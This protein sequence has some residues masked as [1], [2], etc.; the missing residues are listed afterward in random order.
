MKRRIQLLRPQK[1][2]LN[3]L[4][5]ISPSQR[6]VITY[7]SYNHRLVTSF[8]LICVLTVPKLGIADHHDWNAS[9]SFSTE[10]DGTRS[11]ILARLTWNP[12]PLPP[13]ATGGTYEISHEGGGR[14]SIGWGN[15]GGTLRVLQCF[16]GAAEF[17]RIYEEIKSESQRFTIEMN[18]YEGGWHSLSHKFTWKP[19]LVA[20]NP[21]PADGTVVILSHGQPLELRWSLN[22]P[23]SGHHVYFSDDFEDV[24]ERTEDAF[25]GNLLRHPVVGSSESDYPND[26]IPGKTYYWRVDEIDED[27]TKFDGDIWSFWTKPP[28]PITDPNLVCWW[29]FDLSEGIRVID[30]SGHGCEGT[31]GGE[32]QWVDGY[33]GRAV[34]FKAEGDFV[35]RSLDKASDWP[36]G[37]VAFWVKADTVGQDSGG[38]V[39]SS[40][41][42]NFSGF[43]I[44]VDGGNPGNYQVAPGGLTYGA[45]ATDWVHLALTFEN[46]VAKLYYNGSS[47][48]SGPLID[49]MFNQF[50]LGVSRNMANSLLGA[51]DDFFIYDYAL[52]QNE[53]KHVMRANTLV[54]W[55]PSPANGS[56]ADIKE[57]T[58]LRWSPGDGAFQHDVYFG[59]NRSDVVEADATNIS[60]VY[61]GRQKLS[62]YTPT[63]SLGSGQ[64]YFWRIDEVNEL[65]DKTP[66]KGNIWSFTTQPEIAY[67]PYPSD[68]SKLPQQNVILTWMPGSAGLLHDVYFGTDFDHVQNADKFD[69]TGVYQGRWPDMSF[70]IE[71]LDF[72]QTYYW[73]IDEVEADGVTLHKGNIWNFTVVHPEETHYYSDGFETGR[74]AQP[75]WQ[76]SGDAD[77]L[78]SVSEVHASGY[79]AQA[80]NIGDSQSTSLI[81]EGSFAAGHISFWRRVSCEDRFDFLRFYI[82]GKLARMWSGN[83]DWQQ[84]SFPITRGPHTFEWRYTKDSA[85]SDGEDTA[86]ID[87]VVPLPVP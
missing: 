80:G 86:W 69:I 25:L 56:V 21:N 75:P 15:S 33:D 39:F 13:G 58:P 57:A 51:F 70:V 42:G 5:R 53:I 77:W 44:E 36:A 79:S 2:Q 48:E 26:L 24:D 64:T 8:F 7:V 52:T 83:K 54:A 47:I 3:R 61:R 73:R 29:T 31:V 41:S 1:P 71:Q 85:I 68:G 38:G 17:D 60:G 50:A 63:E 66:R 82:D 27:G 87:D 84:V 30:W 19:P 76:L 62:T 35:A 40:Y 46:T 18:F 81:L 78:A 12:P 67:R 49:T 65:N 37:T 6:R 43:Q 45:V 4:V 74:V 72:S 14:N 23:A 11:M 34:R 20:T 28:I 9:A 32:P 22:R 16:C 59:T 55:D 10:K